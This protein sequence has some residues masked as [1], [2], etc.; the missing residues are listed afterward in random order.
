MVI[1]IGYLKRVTKRILTLVITLIRNISRFQN[2]NI[3][4]A[5]F[6]CVYN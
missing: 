1:D 4:Y 2:G 3:L 6:D 5:I